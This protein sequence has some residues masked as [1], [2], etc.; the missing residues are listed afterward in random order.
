MP[1][2]FCP[3]LL[4][5]ALQYLYLH[6]SNKI[7]TTTINYSLKLKLSLFIKSQILLKNLRKKL[8]KYVIHT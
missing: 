5:I 3:A 7:V 8:T 1:V 4:S 6:N 2:F